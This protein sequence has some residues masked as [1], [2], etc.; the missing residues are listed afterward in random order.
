MGNNHS[1]STNQERSLNRTKLISNFINKNN[2]LDSLNITEFHNNGNNVKVPLQ[3]INASSLN[4][5]GGGVVVK[6]SNAFNEQMI[7]H[8]IFNLLHDTEI[9][10][11]HY[12]N[13]KSAGILNNT[14][15]RV[16]TGGAV[17]NEP[18]LVNSDV[19]DAMNRI[20]QVIMAE[21]GAA[22][23]TQQGGAVITSADTDSDSNTN[24]CGCDSGNENEKGYKHKCGSGSDNENGK[25]GKKG[26]KKGK[27]GKKGGK[28]GE[29][30]QRKDSSS[31][32]DSSSDSSS[33][34]SNSSDSNRSDD[35]LKNSGKGLSIFPFNSS[36]VQSSEKN[37]RLMRRKI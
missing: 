8:E 25:K 34:D 26:S 28:K 21:L 32:S 18:A 27:S 20:K 5:V 13:M 19:S 36:D 15:N 35:G 17:A 11:Y 31:S 6:Q 22:N 1:S 16:I 10:Q 12:N 2:N 4:K 9:Q 33:S 23:G 29:K 37:Y 7:K 3:M 30:G 24:G 14:D